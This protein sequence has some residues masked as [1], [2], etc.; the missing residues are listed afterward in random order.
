MILVQASLKPHPELPNVPWAYE[1]AKTADA[2]KMIQALALV[3]GATNRP[4]MLP[5]NT[6]KD[7][8]R[9]L[10][11]AFMDTMKD[12]EF[13]ADTNKAKLDI[14]P[15]DGEEVEKQIKALFKLDPGLVKQLKEV[16]K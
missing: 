7:R 4:Y 2:K 13:L 9:I 3:D 1:L 15:L 5:P 11:K 8:V 14:D 16:L 12:P 10:R 6:P